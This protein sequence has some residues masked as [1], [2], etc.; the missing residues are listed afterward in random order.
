MTPLPLIRGSGRGRRLCISS[1]D[2]AVRHLTAGAGAAPF[3]VA[4]AVAFTRDDFEAETGRCCRRRQPSLP[5]PLQRGALPT[6]KM[7][8][9][10]QYFEKNSE[11]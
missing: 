8:N 7:V 11:W 6:T 2:I 4:A 9:N 5:R 1:R 3:V 10:A